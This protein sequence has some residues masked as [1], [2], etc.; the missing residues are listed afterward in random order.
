VPYSDDLDYASW[1]RQH[2]LPSVL[3]AL[4]RAAEPMKELFSENESECGESH[5]DP[6]L[7]L[8]KRMMEFAK[9]EFSWD[10]SA[11][12]LVEMAGLS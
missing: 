8:R 9:Q 11:Q 2:W 5:Q 12:V 6:L 10:T 7:P 1:V 4:K 3:E